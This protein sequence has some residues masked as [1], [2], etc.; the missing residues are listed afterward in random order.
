M[1]A[2]RTSDTCRSAS[3]CCWRRPATPRVSLLDLLNNSAGWRDV[4][5]ALARRR[6][7]RVPRQ[8]LCDAGRGDA[9]GGQARSRL[10]I[11]HARR[12][13][14]RRRQRHSGNRA[15]TTRAL[16]RWRSESPRPTILPML[17]LYRGRR[18]LRGNSWIRVSE[19]TMRLS[20]IRR[21]RWCAT[22]IR[23][24]CRRTTCST[25]MR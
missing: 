7:R 11:A 21:R 24:G 9:R 3:R 17:A 22:S 16:T 23:S 1:S 5:R 6:L 8:R 25:S 10:V 19:A 15:A 12:H 4:D 14:R 13:W 20:R 2:R 18:T